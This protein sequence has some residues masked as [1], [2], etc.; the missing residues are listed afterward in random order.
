LAQRVE[1]AAVAVL[2]DKGQ[3]GATV[4]GQQRD[5]VRDLVALTGGLFQQYPCR[6]VSAYSLGGDGGVRG[7]RSARGEGRQ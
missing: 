7:V 1:R 3:P 6:R 4:V 5:Q 2:V